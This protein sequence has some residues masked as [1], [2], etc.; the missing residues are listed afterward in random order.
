MR[1][2]N[3][4]EMLCKRALAD[5]SKSAGYHFY[6][7]T[8]GFH[9]RSFESMCVDSRGMPREVKQEFNYMPMNTDDKSLVVI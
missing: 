8:K 9:F 4:I 5:D 3:A 2:F 7:T 1:P 6:E